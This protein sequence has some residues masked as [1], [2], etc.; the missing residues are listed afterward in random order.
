M[1]FIEIR[2][3]VM[4]G[5]MQRFSFYLFQTREFALFFMGS[6]IILGGQDLSFISCLQASTSTK[7]SVPKAYRDITS[8]LTQREE[9]QQLI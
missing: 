9:C 2:K 3:E 7:N 5:K 1:D 8:E 6:L 4:V